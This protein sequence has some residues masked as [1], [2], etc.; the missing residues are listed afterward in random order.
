MLVS[1]DEMMSTTVRVLSIPSFGTIQTT[2]TMGAV[3]KGVRAVTSLFKIRPMILAA[4]LLIWQLSMLQNKEQQRTLE[5]DNTHAARQPA[6]DFFAGQDKRTPDSDS[7]SE[8]SGS[9]WADRLGSA[10]GS[11]GVGGGHQQQR[12]GTGDTAPREL[13]K[14]PKFIPEGQLGGDEPTTDESETA[15]LAAF[16]QGPVD[17]ESFEYYLPLAKS[18]ADLG[19][20]PSSC[21]PKSPSPP[22][23]SRKFDTVLLLA[24]GRSGSSS[25]L[26][27]LNTLPCYN[28]RGEHRLALSSVVL[29]Q[30]F[31]AEFFHEIVKVL[32]RDPATNWKGAR[33]VEPDLPHKPSHFN[34]FDMERITPL[35][36]RLGH[37]EKMSKKGRRG[38]AKLLVNNYLEHIP[39]HVTSGFKEIRI[40][41]PRDHDFEIS[42]EF[43]DEWVRMYPRTAF[44]LLTRN[45]DTLTRS[46]WWRKYSS[47]QAM[48]LLA[49]QATWFDEFADLVNVGNRYGARGSKVAGS[50]V[51]VAAIRVNYE[52]ATSCNL[53]EGSSLAKMYETLG[54]TPDLD[55]CLRIMGNNVEDGGI[56]MSWFDLGNRNGERGWTHGFRTIWPGKATLGKF[57]PLGNFSVKVEGNAKDREFKYWKSP[58]GVAFMRRKLNT[59]FFQ[60]D[61]SQIVPCRRWQHQT[62]ETPQVVIRLTTGKPPKGCKFVLHVPLGAGDQPWSADIVSANT[63]ELPITL[64]P[65]I[66]IEM[67]V[68]KIKTEGCDETAGVDASMVVSRMGVAAARKAQAE[69]S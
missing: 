27:L 58:T 61:G 47:T 46:G 37:P 10:K 65:E 29:P 24:Q 69:E 62:S 44:V 13:R 51:N 59:P 17:Q 35:L 18:L 48:D 64:Q 23:Q 63:V 60:P 11:S 56:A 9:H 43:C 4:V 66:I 34:R 26:R 40:F 55:A 57:Q 32:E 28:I 8:S 53:A 2:K 3:A 7:G 12:L 20:P 1:Y 42:L 14:A 38:V 36:E 54:E 68:S 19:P 39:G 30:N 49:K 5:F 52:D 16:A 31:S 33:Y 45:L 6:D 25:M 15:R 50:N 67:C 21:L 22:N 41:F